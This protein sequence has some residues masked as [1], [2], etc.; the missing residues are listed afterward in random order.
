MLNVAVTSVANRS[1]EAITL[2]EKLNL[3]FVHAVS[4]EHNFDYHLHLDTDRIVL[5][6]VGAKMAPLVVD[7]LTGKNKRR[8][9]QPSRRTQLLAKAA[10]VKPNY[11]PMVL[12][13]T[14]GLAGDAF[15]LASIG[16]EVMCLERNPIIAVLVQDA[17]TRFYHATGKSSL[18]LMY[19]CDSVQKFILS[20]PVKSYDTIYLDPMFP[21]RTKSALVKKDMQILHDLVGV[22]SSSDALLNC[23]KPYARRRVVVKRPLHAPFLDH[24]TPDVQY[25]GR[26]TRYDV[27]LMH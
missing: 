21:D 18:Q 26:S 27:Y 16:C 15:V 2:S 6:K 12:D 23:V 20:L 1:G 5:I 4:A 8:A 17:L 9:E 25:K 19:Q 10:G 7:F 14:A 24:Q 13:C 3:P 22:D 11:C